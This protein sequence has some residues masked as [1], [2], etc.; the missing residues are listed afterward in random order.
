MSHNV[1]PYARA[2]L[3]K[4]LAT[5][6]ELVGEYRESPDS[7]SGLRRP[8]IDALN[9]T[10]LAADCPFEAAQPTAGGSGRLTAAEAEALDDDVFGEYMSKL[11]M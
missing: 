2:G 8:I 6:K 3:Y 5:L 9:Q 7:A 1:P 10:G 4:Q 11:Y